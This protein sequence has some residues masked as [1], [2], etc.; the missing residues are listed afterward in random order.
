MQNSHQV[1]VSHFNPEHKQKNRHIGSQGDG[2]SN[3]HIPMPLY[4]TLYSKTLYNCE[5]ATEQF[6][7]C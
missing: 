6:S 2:I 7:E 3:W 5:S 1:Q 4:K